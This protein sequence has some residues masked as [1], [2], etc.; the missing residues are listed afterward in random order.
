LIV[1]QE[2][3]FAAVEGFLIKSAS[4]QEAEASL[5]SAAGRGDVIW[6]HGEIDRD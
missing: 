5:A 4:F 2:S 6:G 3:F 1:G